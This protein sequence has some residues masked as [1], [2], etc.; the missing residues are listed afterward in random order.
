MDKPEKL[1]EMIDSELGTSL[2]QDGFQLVNTSIQK[3]NVILD[4]TKAIDTGNGW[5]KVKI[6]FTPKPSGIRN[7]FFIYIEVYS[8]Q[9]GIGLGSMRAL[10]ANFL[11]LKALDQMRWT[12]TNMDEFGQCLSEIRLLMED[13][14]FD[15]FDDPVLA[16]YEPKT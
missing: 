14:L 3:E 10:Q 2:I 13:K 1:I 7:E 11:S 5:R 12:Y 15:W 16:P 8:E 4:Y 6:S 9:T